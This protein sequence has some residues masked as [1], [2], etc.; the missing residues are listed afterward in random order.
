MLGLPAHAECI[1]PVTQYVRGH[2]RY[3]SASSWP[4]PGLTAARWNLRGTGGLTTQAPGAGEA[5]RSFVEL[6]VTG[7]CSRSTAQ[8]LIGLIDRT[9][10][11][12]DNRIDEL[13]ALTYTSEP[14]TKQ[15]VINGPIEADLWVTTT[16]A[17]AV[18]SVAVSDVAPD[19]TS[20]GLTNG[21][22]LASNRAVD[23]SRSRLLDGQSIQPWHPFTD[24]A[25]LPVTPGV[26]MLLPVE[27]FPTSAAILPG[28]RLR[29]S[30]APFDVPHALPPLP[31]LLNT[32]AGTVHVLSDAAH[33]SS[34]VLPVVAPEPVARPAANVTGAPAKVP[35]V[36]STAVSQGTPAGG[37][38]QAAVTGTPI[39]ARST[40]ARD[41]AIWVLLPALVFGALVR[42]RRRQ[43]QA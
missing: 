21:L 9:S 7:I 23:R 43:R 14:F 16:S 24:V 26:P 38:A 8:W 12:S 27:V 18:V 41:A 29:V 20:R 35:T 19:G 17:D 1:P 4:V 2:E 6:P 28:H 32:I 10:C 36:R 3:E 15:S 22:L 37:S 5:S 40:A 30:V 13:T 31:G 34:V 39:A 33:P 42:R 25:R 11:A